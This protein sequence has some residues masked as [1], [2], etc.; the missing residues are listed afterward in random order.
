MAEIFLARTKSIQGFEKYLVIKRI[1]GH[2]TQDPE[3]V[4]MF[5]DEARVAAT[6]DH[7]NIVQIYDVGHV[8]NEYFIAMEYLR[9]HNLIEIV[10]AGA[11]LGYAKPPLEHVVSILTQCCAGLHYAHDKRDFEGR[12]LEIVHRDVTPQNVVVSFDG[13]GQGRRLRHRQ[14]GDARSGDARRHA[15]GQDRLHVARAVP[16]ARR[17]I[18]AATSSPSAS[19]CSS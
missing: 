3:F 2:R 16:R 7:P 5:L 18:A 6:L 9:G 10:R 15:Q 4:R 12:R 17:S 1:L 19:S 11:K 8:D 14:G 13:S